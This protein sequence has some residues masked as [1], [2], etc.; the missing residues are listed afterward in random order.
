MKIEA[1]IIIMS[2]VIIAIYNEKLEIEL[3]EKV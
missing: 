1:K 3:R 2:R